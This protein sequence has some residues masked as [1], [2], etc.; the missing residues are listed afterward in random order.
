V[1]T[2]TGYYTL[3]NNVDEISAAKYNLNTFFENAQHGIARTYLYELVDTNS[4][5]LDT[6]TE[7]HYGEF[8][9]DWTPKA[10]ATAIHNL[11]SILKGIG[12][13]T[14]SG[15]LNYSVSGLPKTGRT[16]LLGS[17]TAFDIAIWIDATVYDRKN[18]KEITAHAYSTTVNL[19]RNYASVAVYDP[20]IGD[21]PIAAYSNVSK[22]T[23]NVV[24]H[25]LIVQVN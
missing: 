1:I 8:H 17:G 18:A 3:P 24:D 20:M 25:P 9:D 22:L 13:G 15:L 4:S 12:S 2:E 16:F 5:S 21:R 19:G 11:T 10:G 6:N 7:D 14:P 23:M